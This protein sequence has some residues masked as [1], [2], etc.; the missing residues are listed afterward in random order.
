MARLRDIHQ[1]MMRLGVAIVTKALFNVEITANT[2]I[3]S[4]ALN[5][6][7]ELTSG[8]RLVL[9]PV[10]RLF[11]NHQQSALPACHRRQLDEVVY[12][13][14]RQRRAIGQTAD[15]LLYALLQIQDEGGS[16]MSD[17]QLRDEV[18][19]LLLAGHE[20]TAISLSW[21]WY[22]LA[23]HPA[24]EEKLV[25]E[26]RHVLKSRSPGVQKPVRAYLTR[27]EW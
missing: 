2:D 19:T 7:L 11:S 21:A 25:A 18:M 22:L 27:R 12:G 5:T 24:A 17:D 1:D 8:A 16:S 4:A 6:L 20:T 14:I 10:L 13:L 3:V 23:Q 15:D 9:P 26:L